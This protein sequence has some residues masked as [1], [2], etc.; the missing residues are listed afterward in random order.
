MADRINEFDDDAVRKIVRAIKD[1]RSLPKPRRQQRPV[2]SYFTGLGPF[3]VKTTEAISKGSAG[4]VEIYTGP[5]GSESASGV[6]I[7]VTNK[8]AD[9]AT[10]KWA[11]AQSNGQGLYL[12]AGEC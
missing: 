8:F 5:E 11:W 9:L 12:T 6:E 4:T 10:G 2:A 1:I 3:L 7:S